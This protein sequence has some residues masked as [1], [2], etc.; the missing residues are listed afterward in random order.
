[1]K[2]S[3]CVCLALMLALAVCVVPAFADS[4]ENYQG[5]FINGTFVFDEIPPAGWYYVC[6]VQIL[7][8]L[9]V[10]YETLSP[11]Y[12]NTDS[13]VVETINTKYRVTIAQ[14]NLVFEEY[15]FDLLFRYMVY[16]D[17][18]LFGYDDMS[19]ESSGEI[20]IALIRH[21]P[22]YSLMRE[23]TL[24]V[25]KVFVWLEVILEEL[26]LGSFK[27]VLPLFAVGLAVSALFLGIKIVR[28][29][30]WGT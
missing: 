21:E 22:G 30:T 12:L 18:L 9:R 24:M 25:S 6:F 20:S 5:Y 16:D 19:S 17:C 3:I 11:V 29:F 8:D 15:N 4:S 14:K 1:M 27:P 23:I 2:R 28:K 7:G 26:V 10:Q 13:D